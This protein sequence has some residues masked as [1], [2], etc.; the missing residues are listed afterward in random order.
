MP[1]HSLLWIKSFL[2]AFPPKRLEKRLTTIFIL[3]IALSALLVAVTFNAIS[4]RHWAISASQTAGYEL[5]NKLQA[6]LLDQKEPVSAESLLTFTRLS[7]SRPPISK[8]TVPLI[9]KFKGHRLRAA[10]LFSARPPLPG[11]LQTPPHV[12]PDSFERLA[13]LCQGITRQD[14]AARLFINFGDE[15]PPLLVDATSLWQDRLPET[16]VFIAAIL[17]LC[18][19]AYIVTGISKAISI[20][21]EMLAKGHTQ[22]PDYYVSKEA[23]KLAE[24]I[25]NDAKQKENMLA[26]QTRMLASISHDLRTPATRLRLRL[27]QV[28]N[29]QLRD[30]M[31]GDIEEMTRLIVSSLD[32]LRFEASNEEETDLSLASLL[33]SICDDYADMGECVRLDITNQIRTDQT[34]SVF[35]GGGTVSLKL[36]TRAVMKGRSAGLRRA[37]TNL[38]D[39]AIKYGGAAHITLETHSPDY[40]YVIVSDPGPGIPKD[41]HQKVFEPFFRSDNVERVRSSSVGLGLSIVKQVI[42]KHGGTI[43]LGD[44]AGHGL[45]VYISLP[46][47]IANRDQG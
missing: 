36:Q 13:A 35:G 12:L 40:L 7:T 9:I 15:R 45:Q 26:E 29:D 11:L 16:F 19:L 41:L 47:N 5:G 1:T 39:N 10:I 37:F 2:S 4:A 30:K 6:L 21:F 24:R 20:P 22:L 32:F 44:N 43:T 14:L 38:I 28:Q 46:R 17:L 8:E 42:E 33:E 25:E 23:Y 18:A 34:R 31:V 3:S 27:E